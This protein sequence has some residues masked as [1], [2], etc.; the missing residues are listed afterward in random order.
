MTVQYIHSLQTTKLLT[1]MHDIS[2]MELVEPL[3]SLTKAGALFSAGRAAAI[4]SAQ[5]TLDDHFVSFFY[6]RVW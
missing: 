3:E 5:G 6:F 4:Y 2:V 1:T